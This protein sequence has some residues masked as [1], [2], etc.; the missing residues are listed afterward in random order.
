[1][2]ENNTMK[3][4]PIQVRPYEKCEQF[5]TPTLS[6]VEL[7][8]VILRS[9]TQGKTALDLAWEVLYNMGNEQGLL[10]IHCL[11]MNDLKK[12]KG[13]GRIKAIQIACISELS[14]RLAKSTAS[15]ALCFNSPVTIANYFMEEMRHQKQEHMKLLL[16]DSKSK[17]IAETN[18]SKGTV[19]ASLVTPR[20]IFI[21]AL[22]KQA[23]AIIILHNHP[24][25][26]PS[27]S[28][29]DILVTQRIKNA[30]LLIG[31]ELLDHLIIGNNCYT[32]FCEKDLL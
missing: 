2:N 11:T 4:L 25:G 18:I 9:G 15:S 30:G 29:E 1:M 16:L 32:S 20:E 6:D 13:I 5:G 23:V 7:L 17:L 24:S 10:N 22:Q 19:N 27:P 28:Q 21:E 3:E 31:I 12:I 8:A 14:K 26:D